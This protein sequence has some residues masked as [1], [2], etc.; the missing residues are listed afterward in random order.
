MENRKLKKEIGNMKQNHG[1][2]NAQSELYSR[3]QVIIKKL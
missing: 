1:W 3:Y 2:S